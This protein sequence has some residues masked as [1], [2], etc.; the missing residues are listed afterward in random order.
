MPSLKV[1]L[2]EYCRSATGLTW[3]LPLK[4]FDIFFT[5]ADRIGHLSFQYGARFTD[6][7]ISSTVTPLLLVPA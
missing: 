6:A 1:S 2:A 7:I 3:L 5:G 4:T